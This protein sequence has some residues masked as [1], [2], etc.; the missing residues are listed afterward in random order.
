MTNFFLIPSIYAST[1]SGFL[2]LVAI[3]VILCN[4]KQ[5]R[6][7]ETYK[8]IILIL[9]FSLAIGIHGLSHLGLESVYGY[10][11]M[12]LLTRMDSNY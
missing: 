11:P 7:I 2:I 10:N 3:F 1:M 5:I 12:I 4:L 6:K 8:I 9:G